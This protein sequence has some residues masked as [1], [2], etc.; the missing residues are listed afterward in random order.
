MIVVVRK[1]ERGP[2]AD[3]PKTKAPTVPQRAA[4]ARLAKREKELMRDGV[5]D[6]F[7]V[8]ERAKTRR[9]I[10]HRMVEL[11][12]VEHRRSGGSNWAGSLFRLTEGG[13]AAL[14]RTNT[15]LFTV[16]LTVDERRALDALAVDAESSGA[17]VV[18]E[19]IRQAERDLRRR[20][21]IAGIRE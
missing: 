2:A 20:R 11:G 18:R 17:E 7:W 14:M 15:G 4:L 10:L 3:D 13:R 19:L 9:Q 6:G 16:K 5:R 21:D 12:W 1:L 8:R